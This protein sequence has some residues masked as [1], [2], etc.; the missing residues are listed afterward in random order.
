V[1]TAGSPV[2]PPAMTADA[3]FALMSRWGVSNLAV[4]ES[5]QC[6][7]LLTLDAILTARPSEVSTVPLLVGELCRRPPPVVQSRSGPAAAAEAMA[8]LG[9]DAVVVLNGVHVLGVLEGR[10]AE[11]GLTSSQPVTD[12]SSARPSSGPSFEEK[13]TREA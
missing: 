8:S 13:L 7:G 9:S 11:S 5:G 10:Q 12:A 4:V 2:V 1:L 3:A 6:V